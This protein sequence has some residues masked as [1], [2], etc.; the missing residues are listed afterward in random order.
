MHL[1]RHLELE[2]QVGD[3]GLEHRLVVGR[4][5]LLEILDAVDQRN[6]GLRV[7]DRVE[8]RRARRLDREFA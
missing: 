6:E 4:V 2:V 7:A 3:L 1:D 5:D 8:H